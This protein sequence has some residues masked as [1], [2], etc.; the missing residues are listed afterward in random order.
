MEVPSTRPTGRKP[1]SRT[2]RNSL[3]ERSEVKIEPG[4]PGR[5]SASLRIASCG[6]PCTS[7]S[8]LC[9]SLMLLPQIESYRL[10][11]SRAQ[12]D[13]RGL[14]SLRVQGHDRQ[15]RRRC[16][17]PAEARDRR[18][19]DGRLE[20]VVAP[21][22]LDRALVLAHPDVHLLEHHPVGTVPGYVEL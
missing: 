8:V 3:T 14:A 10:T 4:W 16:R 5:S 22:L 1:T 21:P 2:S 20:H 6:T 9:W 13:A 19:D 12:A 11:G 17:A 15:R 18:A 7:R